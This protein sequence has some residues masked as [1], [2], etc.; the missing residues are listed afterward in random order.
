MEQTAASSH[1]KLHSFD[2]WH[3]CPLLTI[4]K[5]NPCTCPSLGHHQ[6]SILRGMRNSVFTCPSQCCSQGRGEQAVWGTS[7]SYF[8]STLKISCK[9]QLHRITQLFICFTANKAVAKIKPL[10]ETQQGYKHTMANL[11]GNRKSNNLL[12]PTLSS[13]TLRLYWSQSHW[14][15][16]KE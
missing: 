15:Q 11:K 10:C 5:I 2:H 6:K 13:A 9:C 3:Y 12:L 8:K 1:E 4:N 16:A 14:F 7:G